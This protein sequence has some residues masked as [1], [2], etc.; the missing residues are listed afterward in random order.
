MRKSSSSMYSSS[1]FITST[2]AMK[3]FYALTAIVVGDLM[4]E[5]C[6]YCGWYSLC[7]CENSYSSLETEFF[8]R[9]DFCV[10]PDD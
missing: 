10:K 8:L 1:S 7:S 4:D 5:I 9:S 6:V 2:P 3:L